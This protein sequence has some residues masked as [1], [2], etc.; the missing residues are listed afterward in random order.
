MGDKASARESYEEFLSICKMPTPMFPSIDKPKPST[1]SSNISVTK[2]DDGA[3]T[4]QL[5]FL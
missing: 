2:L 3:G 4:Q 1:P 5:I